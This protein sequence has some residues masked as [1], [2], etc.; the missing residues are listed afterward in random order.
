MS[1]AEVFISS[2]AVPPT[3]FSLSFNVE[4]VSYTLGYL[5]L[6]KDTSHICEKK[7]ITSSIQCV[8]LSEE[9]YVSRR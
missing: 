2:N 5:D 3:I 9:V 4:R 7:I 8:V 1:S 6:Y